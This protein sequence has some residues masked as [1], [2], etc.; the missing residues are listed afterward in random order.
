[1][2]RLNALRAGLLGLFAL[3]AFPLSLFVAFP[4]RFSPIRR[5]SACLFGAFP[6]GSFGAFPL[7]LL[8]AFPLDPLGTMLHR[9]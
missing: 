9:S 6:R 1:M 4:L 7:G 2:F 8:G 5:V 3:S